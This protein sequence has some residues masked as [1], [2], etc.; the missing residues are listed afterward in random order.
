MLRNRVL[1]THY[2]HLSML[3][4]NSILAESPKSITD[5]FPDETLS[6]ICEGIKNKD[7]SDPFHQ[8]FGVELIY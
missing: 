3:A 6:V 4:L 7:V 8:S 1:T 2:T 5:K